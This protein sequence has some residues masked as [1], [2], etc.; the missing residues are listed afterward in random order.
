[1]GHPSRWRYIVI[2]GVKVDF[3]NLLQFLNEFCIL[4]HFSSEV[5]SSGGGKGQGV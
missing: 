1:M 4:T 3:K 2:I 5:L